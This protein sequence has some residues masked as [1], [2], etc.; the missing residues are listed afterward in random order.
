MR[1]EFLKT[2]G[3]MF[4][5]MAQKVYRIVEVALVETVLMVVDRF[6][7]TEQRVNRIEKKIVVEMRVAR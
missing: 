4:E 7:E 5:E 2:V 1:E 3:D 6:A